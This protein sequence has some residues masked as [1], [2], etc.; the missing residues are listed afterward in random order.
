M[1]SLAAAAALAGAGALPRS[2]PTV[3][4]LVPLV[5][6]GVAPPCLL[7]LLLPAASRRP[8]ALVLLVGGVRLLGGILVLPVA[9]FALRLARATAFATVAAP[10]MCL[11]PG[12]RTPRCWRWG[13]RAAAAV[14]VGEAR[15]WR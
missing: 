7:V 10:P 1:L 14:V 5:A 15:R 11:L 2:V 8:P 6:A 13:R 12:R 4:V 9:A 3:G